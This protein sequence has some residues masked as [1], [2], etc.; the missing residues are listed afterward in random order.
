MAILES[1]GV[2]ELALGDVGDP[3]AGGSSGGEGLEYVAERLVEV[4]GEF[5]SKATCILDAGSL[6]RG[7]LPMGPPVDDDGSIKLE[8]DPD[9]GAQGR[10]FPTLGAGNAGGWRAVAVVVAR[11]L[12]VG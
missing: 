8:D 12:Q 9:L 1:A 4:D 10:G 7:E 5:E 3:E 6:G 2:E 11:I